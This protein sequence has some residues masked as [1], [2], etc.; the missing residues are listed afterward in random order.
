M[1]LLM[2]AWQVFISTGPEEGAVQLYHTE[3]SPSDAPSA[4][5]WS[6]SPFSL[7]AAPFMPGTLK[8][9]PLSDFGEPKLSASG[10][11]NAAS[12]MLILGLLAVP[13]ARVSVTSLPLSTNAKL[14]SLTVLKGSLSS[15]SAQAPATCGAA[16]E[17]P[18]SEA[19]LPPGTDETMFV[20][21]AS[22][23][24]IE[25]I[26]ESG[27]MVSLSVVLPTAIALEMHAGAA[28]ASVK[29]S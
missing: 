22:R 25:D 6:G 3:F 23:S 18:L 15:R 12:A 16:I 8:V 2:L 21:G 7:V 14:M 19:K 10:L 1:V 20:P 26:L 4:G 29:P 17:V 28:T 13:P 5:R 9:A 11:T 24:T 27:A